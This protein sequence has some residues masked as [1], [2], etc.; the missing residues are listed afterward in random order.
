[1]VKKKSWLVLGKKKYRVVQKYVVE[2][3]VE[4]KK[5]IITIP[6]TKVGAERYIKILKKKHR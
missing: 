4:G 3:S 6:T 5:R 1:M 2:A